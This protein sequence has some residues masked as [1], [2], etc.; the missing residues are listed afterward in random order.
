M[1]S[2]PL[3][4]RAYAKINWVLE[5]LGRREDGF[6]EV[7][8]VLQNVSL[9]DVLTIR[10]REE[11]DI[12]VFCSQAG[13]PAGEANLC[14]RAA[15]RLREATGVQ[16]GASIE[17]EKGIPVA[18]GLGGGSSDAAATL[19]ALNQLWGTGLSL[20]ELT[21]LG[22]GVGSDVPFF[23]AGGTA[24]GTG[25]GEQVRPCPGPSGWPVGLVGAGLGLATAL[26]YRHLQTFRADAGER[27]IQMEQALRQG[28]PL[29]VAGALWNDLEEPAFR[30]RPELGARKRQLR[31]RGVPALLSGS[32]PTLLALILEEGQ[33]ETVEFCCQGWPEASFQVV[34]TMARGWEIERKGGKECPH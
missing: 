1:G 19:V 22:A 3:V 15:L 28:D 29:A 16:A 2:D 26:V 4:I 11:G 24:V 17:I 33:R 20:G 5:V 31:D 27:T 18:A 7:R 8:T 32:G 13:V 9:S 12:Q 14:G 25:R 30:L 21:A 23:L 6:H 34:E 10:V